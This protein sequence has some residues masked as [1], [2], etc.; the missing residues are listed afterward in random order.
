MRQTLRFFSRQLDCVFLSACY[1]DEL[2]NVILNHIPHVI[3]TFKG[4]PKSMLLGFN[5]RFYQSL[6]EGL[7]YRDAFRKANS[8]IHP[9]YV[10]TNK[11]PV[12]KSNL[13]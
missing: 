3:G 2:A 4:T 6:T 9:R 7:D 13:G 8:F 11:R 1:Q 10:P 5:E 12:F